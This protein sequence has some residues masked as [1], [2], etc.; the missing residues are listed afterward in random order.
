[1]E[2]LGAPPLTPMDAIRRL[3]GIKGLRE[4]Y[5]ENLEIVL[6][7]VSA[8]IARLMKIRPNAK[9]VITSDHGELLGEDGLY[10][11]GINHPVVRL[12]PWFTVRNIKGVAFEINRALVREEIRAKL[13]SIKT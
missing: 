7:Y 6:N 12:V 13:R 1:M 10:G 9:I 8:L 5:K 2:A 4:A 3:Y 11:H